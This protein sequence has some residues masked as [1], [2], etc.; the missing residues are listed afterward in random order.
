MQIR[1]ILITISVSL[2]LSNCSS[3]DFSKPIVEQG[4]LL[5]HAKIEQLKTGMDKRSVATLMGTSLLSPTFNNNRW[6]YAYTLRKRG[7]Q[8]QI[9]NLRLYFTKDRLSKIEHN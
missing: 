9:D 7:G 8:L 6:D 2:I 1:T 4:N 5:P 3:Y